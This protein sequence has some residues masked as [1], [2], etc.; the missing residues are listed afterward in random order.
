[1]RYSVWR[2]TN[3]PNAFEVG[4]EGVSPVEPSDLLWTF[5]ADTW[6]AA[7]VRAN[8][9]ISALRRSEQLS[10]GKKPN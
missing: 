5:D 1:V 2:T 4:P 6:E 7:R 8:E 9:L 3:N 10:D